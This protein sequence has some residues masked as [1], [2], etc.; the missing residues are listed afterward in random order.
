MATDQYKRRTILTALG[1]LGLGAGA[2]ITLRDAAPLDQALDTLDTLP[3][4]DP[5]PAMFVGHGTPMGALG[6]NVWTKLR[7]NS[8]AMADMSK[9]V[10]GRKVA[11]IR[12][13][14]ARARSLNGAR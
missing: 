10:A 1:A 6:P 9:R 12:S 3:N 8:A 2:A 11:V 4:T 7:S 14:R 13:L 5:M